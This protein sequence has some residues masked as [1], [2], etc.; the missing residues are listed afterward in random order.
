VSEIPVPVIIKKVDVILN[1]PVF[2]THGLTIITDGIKNMF[3]IIP[4]GH[5]TYLHPVVNNAKELAE[6]LVD[7]YRG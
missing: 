2:K 1:L 4:A 7:I 3:G 6:L 5:K